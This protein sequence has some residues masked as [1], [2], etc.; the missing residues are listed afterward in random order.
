[1]L[2]PR[3]IIISSIMV[4]IIIILIIIIIIATIIIIVITAYRSHERGLQRRG[5]PCVRSEARPDRPMASVSAVEPWRDDCRRLTEVA[6]AVP[7]QKLTQI[8]QFMMADDKST[9]TRR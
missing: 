4:I 5:S 3:L 8:R 1:M 7:L 6:R 2:Q 9:R